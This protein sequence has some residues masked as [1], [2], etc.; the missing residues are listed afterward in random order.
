[1][2][3]SKNNRGFNKFIHNYLFDLNLPFDTHS[4]LY[5]VI[6]K[7]LFYY[8]NCDVRVELPL[9]HNYNNMVYMYNNVKDDI[10]QKYNNND[11]SMTK[12]EFIN[13]IG[14]YYLLLKL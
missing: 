3:K 10:E 8:Y 6:D 4:S 9:Y 12:E 1:M 7:I 14:K 11:N 2:S 5:I 13:L